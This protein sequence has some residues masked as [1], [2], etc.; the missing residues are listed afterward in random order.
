MRSILHARLHEPRPVIEQDHRQAAVVQPGLP[1]EGADLLV[2]RLHVE[3]LVGHAIA[4]EEVFERV[5]SSRP[6]VTD[7]AEARER[8]TVVGLP[9]AEQVVQ[10]GVEVLLRGSHG[11]SA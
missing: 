10:D 7:H 3:P 8:R 11:F 1:E 5:R 2:A 6:A 9:I 4:A